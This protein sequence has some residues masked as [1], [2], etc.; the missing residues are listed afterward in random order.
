MDQGPRH[1]LPE[2]VSSVEEGVEIGQQGVA[3]VQIMSGG[4]QQQGVFTEGGG[5]LVLQCKQLLNISLREPISLWTTNGWGSPGRK[6]IEY[7]TMNLSQVRDIG[8][9]QLLE[10]KWLSVSYSDELQRAKPLDLKQFSCRS[11]HQKKGYATL[12]H[13]AITKDLLGRDFQPMLYTCP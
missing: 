3:D 6:Y 8:P 11:L 12:L 9:S 13:P 10:P 1:S 7:L 5:I 2:A 4:I